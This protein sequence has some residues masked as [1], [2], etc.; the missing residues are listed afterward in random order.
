[1]IAFE[2]PGTAGLSDVTHILQ[3][4]YHEQSDPVSVCGC[5]SIDR[6]LPFELRGLEAALAHTTRA[7]EQESIQIERATLPSLKALLNKVRMPTVALLT[8]GS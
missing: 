7:L 1:M 5:S 3:G 6:T 8:D 2:Q 4:N